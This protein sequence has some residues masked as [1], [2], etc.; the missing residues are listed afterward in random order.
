MD[1]EIKREKRGL[2]HY[3]RTFYKERL[4]MPG[5]NCTYGRKWSFNID[6]GKN[7]KTGKR[8]RILEAILKTRQETEVTASNLIIEINQNT[9]IKETEILFKDRADRGCQKRD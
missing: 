7:P 5:Y 2:N 4:Q 3:E 9:F 8:N 1:Y 6:A